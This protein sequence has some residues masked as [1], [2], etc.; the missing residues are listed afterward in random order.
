MSVFKGSD[1]SVSASRPDVG[2]ALEGGVE[3]KTADSTSR[4]PDDRPG[5][6]DSGY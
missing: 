6:P 4:V 2:Q 3:E 5:G 1:E